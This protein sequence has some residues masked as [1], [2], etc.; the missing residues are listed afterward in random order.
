MYCTV[1]SQQLGY[2]YLLRGPRHNSGLCCFH[3]PQY[4]RRVS[5]ACRLP[6]HEIGK[7][8]INRRSDTTNV[9]RKT[10]CLKTRTSVRPMRDHGEMVAALRPWCILSK[11]A[12][13]D[14]RGR[15]DKQFGPRNW[16]GGTNDVIKR[17]MTT[18]AGEIMNLKATRQK[19]QTCDRLC[20]QS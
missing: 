11:S 18:K 1:G 13:D 17:C 20:E 8:K 12:T 10:K 7:P 5:Y 16:Q 9:R 2:R 3:L 6:D 19:S 14:R 4:A 15:V